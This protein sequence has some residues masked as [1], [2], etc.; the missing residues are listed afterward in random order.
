MANPWVRDRATLF[1]IGFGLVGLSVVALGFGVTYVVPMA[2][3]TFFAPWF[4]HLHGASALGWILL[5]IVQAKL[6][7]GRRTP[8]HRRLGQVALP[9]A[10]LVWATGIATAVWAAA[11][12]LPKSGTAATSGLGGTVT[13]LSL[14]LLLAIA[15]VATRR[16]PDWH[17]RLVVLA[18]I[19][20]LWPAFFRLRH[21]LPGVPNPD[22]WFALVLAYLPILVAALRD[23][24]RD[25]KIHPVW[26]FIGPALILEQSVEFALFDQG[27]QR[28][29]GQWVYV[30][31]T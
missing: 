10:L 20:V 8:L 4:V 17:K 6:V 23:Q 11:R 18:T 2:R 16:R 29:F 1:Y 24:W 28:R 21:W 13:G 9:L 22:I 7:R 3:R 30:L 25:G 19:Q 15:A 27:L 26:L 14:F 12:D 31:L 5:L